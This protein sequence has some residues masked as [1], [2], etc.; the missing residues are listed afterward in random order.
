SVSDGVATVVGQQDGSDISN[1]SGF[2]VASLVQVESVSVASGVSYGIWTLPFTA[3]PEG[4]TTSTIEFDIFA[5]Q[6]LGYVNDDGDIESRSRTIELQYRPVGGSTWTT[7]SRSI[8]GRTRDQLGWSWV[9]NL[10]SSMRPEVRVRR[11][12]SE[13]NDVQAM[14]RLEWYGL[15]CQLPAKTSYPGVTVIAMTITGSDTIASQTENKVSLIATRKLPT[16]SGGA[17]TA[18]QATRDIVP[19]LAYIAKSVGY[20]DADLDLDEMDRLD[21]IWK[22]RGDRFDFVEADDSTVKESLNRALR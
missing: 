11:V 22:G 16:R 13:D 1:W 18:P 14:D 20:T 6:G 4:E 21:A 12:S 19:W 10:S 9:V 3:C 17:W 8:T 15:R 2:P 7:V 5:P